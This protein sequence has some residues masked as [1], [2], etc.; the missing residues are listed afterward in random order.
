M[1]RILIFVAIIILSFVLANGEDF[2]AVVADSQTK[3]PL[4]GASVFEKSGKFVG[5]CDVSGRLPSLT[6]RDYPISVRHLGYTERKVV[7]MQSD[8]IFMEVNELSLPEVVIETQEHKFLHMLAYL[9]EYSTLTTY[10]DTIFLFR[11]KMVDFMLPHNSKS[12]FTGWTCPR[13]LKSRSYYRFTNVEG[14]DSVSD[15]R[16]F[17][18]VERPQRLL[19]PY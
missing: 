7:K 2:H 3:T 1:S 15:H 8:T 14:L 9:R 18:S 11:E 10:T 4:G 16:G 5:A 12:K 19:L 13:V 17:H 6:N